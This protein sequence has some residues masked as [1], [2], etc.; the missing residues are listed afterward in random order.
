LAPGFSQRS[1][2]GSGALFLKPLV[3]KAPTTRPNSR[4]WRRRERR[5]AVERGQLLR[6]KAGLRRAVRMPA[7]RLPRLPAAGPSA[8]FDGSPGYASR[9][10]ISLTA[11]AAFR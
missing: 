5:G 2:P 1:S 3:R 9:P 6:V 4:I 11:S 8:L 10:I 7:G